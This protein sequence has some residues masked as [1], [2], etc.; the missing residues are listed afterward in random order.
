VL[1]LIPAAMSM[2]ELGGL[3]P[4]QGGVYVWACRMM[5]KR[6]AFFGGFLSWIPVILAGTLNPAAILSYLGRH[7]QA[8]ANQEP[9]R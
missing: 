1:F 8:E 5:N 7:A 2:L 6:C 9:R 3:W 4:S